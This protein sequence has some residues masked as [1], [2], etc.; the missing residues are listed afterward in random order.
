MNNNTKIVIAV[1]AVVMVMCCVGSVVI[2]AIGMATSAIMSNA[3]HETSDGIRTEEKSERLPQQAD[4]LLPSQGTLYQIQLVGESFETFDRS[5]CLLITPTISAPG[6][7]ENGV[8]PLEVGI[9]SGSPYQGSAGAISWVTN[10]QLMCDFIPATC[11]T[12]SAA[13]D[14]AEVTVDEADNQI[15]IELPGIPTAMTS[16][17]NI[18]NARSGVTANVYQAVEGKMVI[19]FA[20]DGK[21]TGEVNFDG[22]GMIS[23]GTANYQATFEGEQTSECR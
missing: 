7:N 23:A 10:T 17:L 13:L 15:S 20:P 6:N 12:Q 18:F 1:V 9:F 5:G 11:P 2:G 22:R 3:S 19:E 14:M 21:V 8:N 16:Q 4:S